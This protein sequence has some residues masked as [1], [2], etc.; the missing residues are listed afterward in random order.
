MPLPLRSAL[1]PLLA[2]SA[3]IGA[4]AGTP[5][6]DDERPRRG[7]PGEERRESRRE[8]RDGRDETNGTSRIREDLQTQLSDVE[9]RL[10]LNPPQSPHWDR[11][12]EAIGALMADQLRLD[13]R[14]VARLDAL[15]QI[16]RRVDVV[17]NRLVA[18]ED[19][20]D[21]AK[22]LYAV[23]DADQRRV[24]DRLLPGTVPALYSGLGGQDTP[25]RGERGAPPGGG[26]RD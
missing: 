14:P 23:L 26:R 1:V 8:S 13:P 3:L 25:A 7:P 18:M 22:A 20:A 6:A 12:R 4:C 21:A 16:E 5:A 17:R 15:R 24:A 2:L 11:Y 19:I 10:K 9:A